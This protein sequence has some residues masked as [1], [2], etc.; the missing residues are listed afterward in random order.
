MRRGLHAY[1]ENRS[2]AGLAFQ[3]LPLFIGRSFSVS[4]CSQFGKLGMRKSPQ[5]TQHW[6]GKCKGVGPVCFL[7]RPHF[8]TDRQ[9]NYTFLERLSIQKRNRCPCQ[10]PSHFVELCVNPG[11]RST[12]SLAKP[13]FR[14]PL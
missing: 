8:T 10:S 6:A 7:G 13:E 1:G 9:I 3:S 11:S 5:L 4:N 12:R 2:E 14:K